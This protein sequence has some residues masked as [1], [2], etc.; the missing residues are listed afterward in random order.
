MP[1]GFPT[2]CVL[3]R[4][5]ANGWAWGTWSIVN[6]LKLRRAQWIL[7][8]FLI[9]AGVL[10]AFPSIDIHISRLFFDQGFPLKEQWTHRLIHEGMAYF[11]CGSLGTVIGIYG[12]NRLWQRN[13]WNIDGRKVGYLLLV[14]IL[15]AGLM[16]NVV[17]KDGFGRARPRDIEEFG[18]SRQFTPAFVIAAE[19]DKNCSFS[20]GEGAGGFFSLA[21]AAALSRRRAALVAAVGLG[22]VVSWSRI[23]SGAHFFSDTVVSFFVMLIFT[24]ALYYY[25]FVPKE[26]RQPSLAVAAVPAG[27]EISL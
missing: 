20:S 1:I 5:S 2:P 9:S 27:G 14:L 6:Y 10:S 22:V 23:A 13:I 15:G 24:D 17:L 18:G 21:L 3:L 11:L 4:I 19:C 7:A 26:V 8:C 25:M 16:V 12:Y